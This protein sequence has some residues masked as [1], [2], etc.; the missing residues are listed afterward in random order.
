VSNKITLEILKKIGFKK[1]YLD[2]RSAHWY[3]LD[4]NKLF[5]ESKTIPAGII[6][7]SIIYDELDKELVLQM[8]VL[9]DFK[10]FKRDKQ[11]SML[12]I[13]P[14]N[15]RNLKRLINNAA[16]ICNIK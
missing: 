7:V 3:H 12:Q 13:A 5:K 16:L 15:L 1:K 4:C 2:D 8:K 11:W 9:E 6:P 10:P 14:A